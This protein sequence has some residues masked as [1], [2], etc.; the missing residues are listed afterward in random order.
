MNYG[1][2]IVADMAGLLTLFAPHCDDRS[3]LDELQSLLGDHAR[4]RHGHNLFGRIRDKTL[5]AEQDGRDALA[6]QYLFEE[7]IAKTLYNMSGA[8]APFDS[9]SAYWVVPNA[10]A[11]AR[12]LD[13][14]TSRVVDIVLG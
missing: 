6:A 11:L 7:A 3:T 1:G 12:A 9:D 5:E 14:A 2:K 8:P 4:W 10:L 13:F